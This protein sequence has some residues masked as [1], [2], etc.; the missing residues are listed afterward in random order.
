M[1]KILKYLY[2]QEINSGLGEELEKMAKVKK[3]H[4]LF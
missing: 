2:T 4:P 3:P 1:T